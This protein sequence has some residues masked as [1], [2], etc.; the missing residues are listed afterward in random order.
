MNIKTTSIFTALVLLGLSPAQ[1]TIKA[2]AQVT[3]A[4]SPIQITLKLYSTKVKAGKSVW[5]KIELKNVGKKKILV[6]DWIFKDPW[7]MH[8][9]CNGRYGIYLDVIDEKG[10]RPMLQLGGGRVHYKYEPQPGES[11][12]LD[13]KDEAERIAYQAALRKRG[14]TE[15]EEHIA[16]IRWDEAWNNRQQLKEMSDPANQL[17]LK[18][19]ASTTTIAWAYRDDDPYADHADEEAQIGDYTQLWSYD[20]DPGKYRIRAIYDYSRTDSDLKDLRRLK[21]EPEKSWIKVMSPFIE[22]KVLP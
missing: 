12:P 3:A 18:P 11:K 1:A 13:P 21:I 4:K 9:N 5:Y 6:D 7:G 20:L 17:W 2:A 10:E 16:L 22:F 14:L 8:Q 15:Q 19:G